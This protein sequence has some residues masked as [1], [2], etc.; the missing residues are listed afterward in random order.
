MTRNAPTRETQK[1][2]GSLRLPVQDPGCHTFPTR[3]SRICSCWF[4][5]VAAGG[6]EGQGHVPR[7]N[8]MWEPAEEPGC[9]DPQSSSDSGMVVVQHVKRH[10]LLARGV[11][12]LG[13]ASVQALAT[14][15]VLRPYGSPSMFDFG[16][17]FLPVALAVAG[18]IAKRL[19]LRRQ[20]QR[21]WVC[22]ITL[23]FLAALCAGLCWLASDLGCSLGPFGG[24]L[25]TC[26][27]GLAIPHSGP[28]G[29]RTRV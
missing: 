17:D 20:S 2:K 5:L 1:V 14:C 11:W 3:G 24:C 26:P 23:P 10:F 16:V 12:I 4:L 8:L 7:G 28:T 25:Q 13:G 21:S 15:L 29:F 19:H 22:R 18:C 6:G 27:Q 9:A